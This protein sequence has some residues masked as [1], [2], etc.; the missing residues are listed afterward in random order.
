MTR[1]YVLRHGETE[2]NH[3]GNKYCG[4]TD[5]LLNQTGAEQAKLAAAAL[6]KEGITAIYCSTLRR[7]QQ[8]AEIIGNLLNLEPVIDE[9]IRE[10]DFGQ[11]EGKTRH[12]LESEFSDA[13]NAWLSDPHSVRAG[14][15]GDTG[16]EVASRYLSFVQEQYVNR[17]HHKILVVGHNTSNRLF[18]AASLD[19]SFSK[20]RSF[21]QHN[22]AIS[23][24]EA[25]P[26]KSVW[27]YINQTAHLNT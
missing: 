17:P 10:I 11:W 19:L 20:Y 9:R 21:V 3:Q 26:N 7:S 13:W 23:L 25:S 16:Y 5:I 4:I 8:T 22:A 24:L 14:N 12:E 18:L 1:F 2:W 27:V 6:A 15:T